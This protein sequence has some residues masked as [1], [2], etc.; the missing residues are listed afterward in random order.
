MVYPIVRP[1]AETMKKLK[2]QTDSAKHSIKSTKKNNGQKKNAVQKNEKSAAT[3]SQSKSREFQKRALDKKKL[4]AKYYISGGF[5]N[6]TQ[7]AIKAGYAKKSATSKAST[8]LCDINVQKEL[9]EGRKKAAAILEENYNWTLKKHLKKLI[10]AVNLDVCEYFDFGFPKSLDECE[11][12]DEQEL[13]NKRFDVFS[14]PPTVRL[15][16]SKHLTVKQRQMI[17]GVQETK[18]GVKINFIEKNNCLEQLGQYLGLGKE[19]ETDDRET[20]GK[21]AIRAAISKAL[22]EIGED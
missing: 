20:K 12:S 19:K 5:K 1:D 15:K 9:D 13:F 4:F 10:D 7:A 14:R 16:W 6:A 8:L 18:H 11:T 2:K 17:T 21:E 3:A 22:K